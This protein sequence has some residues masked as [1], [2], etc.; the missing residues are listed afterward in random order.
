MNRSPKPRGKAFTVAELLILVFCLSVI[1]VLVLP[2]LA[3]NRAHSRRIQCVGN[4]KQIGLAF[5]TWSLPSGDGFPMAASVTKGGTSE[6]IASGWVYPHFLAM[7][8]ELSTPM[9]LVCP[10]DRLRTHARSFTSRFDDR[11]VSYFVGADAADTMP[12]MLLSGDDNLLVSGQPVKRRLLELPTNAP[13]AWSASRH[14]NQGNLCLAD[15]SVQQLSSARL[16]L[17]VRWTG[18]ATNR[19]LM[20]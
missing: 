2:A 8:N 19:L 4:L 12:N 5:R 1:A 13:V 14:V 9:I 16:V 18:A 17:C 6:L 7:S 20:P 11:N 15:G 10:E 3:A